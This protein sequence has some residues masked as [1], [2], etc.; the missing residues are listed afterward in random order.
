MG[1]W[2][3][4]TD[5]LDHQPSSSTPTAEFEQTLCLD[6]HAVM[7]L[8]VRGPAEAIATRNWV[9]GMAQEFPLL[10]LSQSK[11]WL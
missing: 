4:I 6:E 2:T 10:F 1:D 9:E 7:A 8:V 11:Q 3:L 5:V